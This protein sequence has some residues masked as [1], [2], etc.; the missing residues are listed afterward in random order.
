MN[1]TDLKNL[2]QT[3][4]LDLV[5]HKHLDLDV[6]YFREKNLVSTTE[7][8]AVFIWQQLFSNLNENVQ[9]YEIKIYETE[10]NIVIYRGE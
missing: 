5:D 7:N 10:K 9:L 1:I 4:V 2:I 3:Y 6:Q 8:L